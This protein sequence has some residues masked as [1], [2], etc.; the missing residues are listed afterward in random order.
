M[1]I[2]A[3]KII[4]LMIVCWN[5]DRMCM[6]SEPNFYDIFTLLKE[7]FDTPT[8]PSTNFNEWRFKL[9]DDYSSGDIKRL[10]GSDGPNRTSQKSSLLP[11]K[12][13]W[14]HYTKGDYR[15]ELCIGA[16]LVHQTSWQQVE[17]SIKGI[18]KHLIEDGNEFNAERIAGIPLIELE[19][20]VRS[21]GFY[22]Q[23]ARRVQ[24]FCDHIVMECDDIDG[25]FARGTERAGD[26]AKGKKWNEM[27][28]RKRL[29]NELISLKLGFGQETRDSVLLYAANAPVFIADSYA[30]KLLMLLGDDNSRDYDRCQ[31][32]F[33]H[34]IERDF[35]GEVKKSLV[36][37]YTKDELVYALPNSPRQ[38]D[39]PNI[40]LY[41]Q[42]HAGIDELGISKLWKEFVDELSL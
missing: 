37:E 35:S 10:V 22:R 27:M 8:P 39:I 7:W 40:L 4:C 17:R 2:D 28:W 32:R 38:E 5:Q 18:E 21:T 13:W 42:F 14:P 26:N 30:R 33:E 19:S 29:G 6:R 15:F 25:F 12:T 1:E 24:G 20:L 3:G 16:L 11:L 41:Q 31:K 36:E 9:Y 34:G 23:K